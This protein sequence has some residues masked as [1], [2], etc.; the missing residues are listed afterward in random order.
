MAQNPNIDDATRARALEWG[1]DKNAPTKPRIVGKKELEDSGLSLRDFLNK[2]RGLTR[3]RDP[4]PTAGNARNK[5]EQD[6]ADAV[7]PGKDMG[8]VPR[9]VHKQATDRESY[10][11]RRSSSLSDV[12]RPGTNVN[13]ENQDVSDMTFKRGGVV[14][15]RGDG[16]AQRGKTRA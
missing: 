6:D 3:R 4:D 8:Y 1:K 12:T 5:K 9:R 13:Y 10:P 11:P 14:S 7:D 16:I 2:E 15:R